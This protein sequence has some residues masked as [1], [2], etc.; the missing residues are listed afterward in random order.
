MMH[1]TVLG[2]EELRIV[3]KCFESSSLCSLFAKDLKQKKCI[4]KESKLV[5]SC[6]LDMLLFLLVQVCIMNIG[7][8]GGSTIF[9]YPLP[10]LFHNCSAC[11]A[12]NCCADR[13]DATVVGTSLKKER[14]ASP[15]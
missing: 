8:F 10:S 1:P 2:G 11:F 7:L 6:L 5:L 15:S 14:H 3:D 4:I 13:P 9:Q 12:P